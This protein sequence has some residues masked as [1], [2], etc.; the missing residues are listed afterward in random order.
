MD[1]GG[2][3]RGGPG[4]AGGAA[5]RVGACEEGVAARADLGMHWIERVL[6]QRFGGD[7]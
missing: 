5:A 3:W 6:F 4:G 2:P 7:G 1:G